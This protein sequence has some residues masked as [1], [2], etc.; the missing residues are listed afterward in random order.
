MTTT[1]YKMLNMTD[2]TRITIKHQS[3]K[4]QPNNYVLNYTIQT[5]TFASVRI[6]RPQPVSQK[7]PVKCLRRLTSVLLRT[8]SK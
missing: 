3:L 1:L 6:R 2:I 4:Y 7:H 8:G 5:Q